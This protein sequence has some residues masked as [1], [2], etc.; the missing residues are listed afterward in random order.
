MIITLTTTTSGNTDLGVRVHTRDH[1]DLHQIANSSRTTIFLQFYNKV[2][3]NVPLQA[4]IDLFRYLT[5]ESVSI[6]H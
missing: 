4:L 6:L 1:E 2:M 5:K 3:R